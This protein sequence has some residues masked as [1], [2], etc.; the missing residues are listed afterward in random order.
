MQPEAKTALE[1]ARHA[2]ALI[3]EFTAGNTLSDYERSALLRS[4]VERQFE[5]VGE[6][7]NRLGKID[8]TR[9]RVPSGGLVARVLTCRRMLATA[10]PRLAPQPHLR[11]ESDRADQPGRDADPP[12][13]LSRLPRQLDEGILHDV[14]GVRRPEP[15]TTRGVEQRR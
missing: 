9:H 4:A 2:G 12:R 1:D 5:V 15:R 8:R 3:L 11:L 10:A 13:A 6:A 14:L 7:L